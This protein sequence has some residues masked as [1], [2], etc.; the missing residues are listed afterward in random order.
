MLN[1]HEVIEDVVPHD[2]IV[3]EDG[4]HDDLAG[5]FTRPLAS[6][7][8]VATVWLARSQPETKRLVLRN[9]LEKVLEVSR[10]VGVPHALERRLQPPAIEWFSRRIGLAAA[11]L[12]SAGTPSLAR[13]TNG[14]TRFFQQLGIGSELRWQCAV[15]IP[16]FFQTPD[17]LVCENR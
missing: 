6:S 12:E 5:I 7:Q 15:N 9:V 2:I 14:V 11:W 4:R 8:F 10:I 3:R 17:L 1:F 16:G 13:V